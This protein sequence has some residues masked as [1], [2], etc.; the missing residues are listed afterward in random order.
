MIENRFVAKYVGAVPGQDKMFSQSLFGRS[1]KQVRSPS[2][3]LD[4]VLTWI[5]QKH[6]F[7]TSKVRPPTA[8]VNALIDEERAFLLATPLGTLKRAKAG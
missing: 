6:G 4:V 7:L 3:A 2:Q 1:Y 8:F 5:W